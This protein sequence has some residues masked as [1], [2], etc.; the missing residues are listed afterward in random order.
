MA[1][2]D[3]EHAAFREAAALEALGVLP[4][5]ASDSLRAHLHECDVCMSEYRGL[6]AV[7]DLLGHEVEFDGI[8]LE[9]SDPHGLKARVMRAARAARA[10][11]V[12]AA[13]AVRGVSAAD[14][15]EYGPGVK[16]AVVPASGATIVY[17]A[18][19]PP[20]CTDVPAESHYFSQLGVVLKGK[21]SMSFG[22][23][24]Q[25]HYG[26]NEIYTIAPGVVHGAHFSESTLL[27]EVYTPNHTEFEALF[28]KQRGTRDTKHI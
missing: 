28:A 22:D 24:T 17:W 6:R 4:Q 8:R 21:M 12:D 2:V 3:G 14:L 11:R 9:P 10:P 5:A 25:Q 19:D 23:G 15:I 18:F 20:E 26:P 13:Y 1:R 7:A 27:V 16:W